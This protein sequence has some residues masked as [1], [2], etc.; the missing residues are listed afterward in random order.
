MFA[1]FLGELALVNDPAG[2]V[3]KRII[4]SRDHICNG[5]TALIHVVIIIVIVP[6]AP[7]GA[8]IG[9][10]AVIGIGIVIITIAI[11]VITIRVIAIRPITF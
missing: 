11:V 8:A 3:G 2:V 4:P 6:F 5:L 1:L 7:G 10:I 9:V